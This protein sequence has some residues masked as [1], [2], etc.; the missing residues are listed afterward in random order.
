MPSS[1]AADSPARSIS[2]ITLL[3]ERIRDDIIYGR[4]GPGSKLKIE[5]LQDRYQTGATPLREALSLL[6]A[7]GLV[8]R[9]EQRGFRVVHVS[10]A[11]FDEL[12]RTRCFVEEQAVRESVVAGDERWEDELN[13]ATYRLRR[14]SETNE[15]NAEDAI[16]Q[17]E[18]LHSAFHAA[19]IAACPSRFLLR[20]CQ[21]LYQEALRYRYIARLAPR[22]RGAAFSEHRA[23]SEAALA[24]DAA[25][26]GTL[27]V[28]HYTLT[29]K[30]LRKALA[31]READVAAE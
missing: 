29:G 2:R 27:L 1:N 3:H 14:A 28:Q 6:V 4:I 26:T 12:L 31:D 5:T 15:N 7:S 23:I 22:A 30:L 10:L 13:L 25:L 20:F 19:L 9:I 16:A 11:E 21:Q 18:H 8:E 17:W 24:R